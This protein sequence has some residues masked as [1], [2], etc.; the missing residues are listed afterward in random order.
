MNATARLTLP[1]F[2]FAAIAVACGGD[3][4]TPRPPLG[5]DF[6]AAGPAD[7]ADTADT[8]SEDAPRA[9]TG[10][11]PTDAVVEGGRFEDDGDGGA[12][13]AA[14]NPVYVSVTVHLEGWEVER[15]DAYRNY[16]GKLRERADLFEAWGAKLTLED[17][18]LSA[19]TVLWGDNV[20]LEMQARGHAVGLHAD[21]GSADDYTTEQFTLDLNRRRE[22][23]ESLG[24]TVRHTSG[25]CSFTDWVTAAADA[26]LEFSSSVIEYCLQSL[27]PLARPTEYRY[28]RHPSA[29]HDTWPPELEGRLHPRTVA[30]GE[31]WDE[32]DPEGPFS[33]LTS[34]GEI[35]CLAE[36]AAGEV[37]AT[38]CPFNHQDITIFIDQLE[39]AIDIAE[40]TGE[41]TQL[42]PTWSFGEG[43]GLDMLEDWL[44]AI[45][46]Y[47]VSGHVVWETAP[48]IYDIYRARE[49]DAVTARR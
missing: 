4:P 28:C 38:S 7:T 46:A 6:D 47:V 45:D 10:P 25:I 27:P 20:L 30:D 11:P 42:H 40:E 49:D 26:G 37:S 13:W 8:A 1:R 44:E 24:L 3:G 35:R 14:A 33:L 15:F 34:T 2:A 12:A 43:L 19:G 23:V 21:L 22:R 41:V 32:D 18:N 36:T 29:C 48:A 31:T 5:L 39:A 9:D 16:V 17:R